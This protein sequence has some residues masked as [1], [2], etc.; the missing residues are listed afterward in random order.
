MAMVDAHY[1]FI[2]GSCG[3][4]GNTHDSIIFQSI[5][6]WSKIQKGNYLTQIAKKVDSQD[7]P[8]LVVGDSAFPFASWLMKPSTNAILTEKQR[9]FN[10]R[11]I[12]ARM[13]TEGNPILPYTYTLIY[14]SY[15]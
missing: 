3:Y 6:L 4:P 7:V 10:Y 1:R 11:L 12:R 2:W 5:D 13:V 8:P 14:N 9:Y 15:I